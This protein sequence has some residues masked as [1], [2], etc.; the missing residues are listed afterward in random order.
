MIH[1]LCGKKT[2]NVVLQDDI[3]IKR[4]SGWVRMGGGPS[5]LK[6]RSC[7][8]PFELPSRAVLPLS[9]AKTVTPQVSNQ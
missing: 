2:P 7:Q 1:N 5:N 9:H 6:S 4:T 3:K 8:Q